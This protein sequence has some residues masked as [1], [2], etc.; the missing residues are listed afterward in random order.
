VEFQCK[1]GQPG[2]ARVI[3]SFPL[4]PANFVSFRIL[5]VCGNFSPKIE[6]Y[7][8]ASRIMILGTTMLILVG[9]LCL[10]RTLKGN[11]NPYAVLP[12]S[13]TDAEGEGLLGKAS[14]IDAFE[15]DVDSESD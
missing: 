10:Y 8:T 13:S 11:K 12:S 9:A 5:K 4:V 1:K 2:V 7:W 6:W 3:V 14:N 15:E